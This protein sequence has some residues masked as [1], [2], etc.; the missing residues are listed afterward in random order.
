[1]IGEDTTY[2]GTDLYG[3]RRLCDLLR[4]LDGLAGVRWIRLMYAYP[5]CFDGAA[6][7]AIA[8]CDNIAK[9]VDIP[10]QHTATGVLKRMGRKE[11]RVDIFRIVEHLRTRVP[12][13][14][15]R[16]T[17]IAGFPGETEA[18]HEALLADLADLRLDRVGCF[19]YSTEGNP[20]AN[21]LDGGVD[22]TERLRRRNAVMETQQKISWG[23]N[24]ARIGSSC[25]VVVDGPKL[26]AEGVWTCRSWAEA[27]EIDGHIEVRA[28]RLTTG[29][30]LR[31]KITHAGPYDLAAVKAD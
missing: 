23:K 21:R 16:S 10:F 5:T 28:K 9:Y 24:R 7:D 18:Q 27:P 22:E 19:P 14:A 29:E 12:E 26:E 3:R 15:L 2:Y 30:R 6:V 8:E 31:V 25:E 11:T 4:K 1:M 20:A 13:I 17:F